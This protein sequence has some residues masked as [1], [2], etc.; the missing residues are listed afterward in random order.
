MQSY[1]SIFHLRFM[2]FGSWLRNLLPNPIARKIFFYISFYKICIFSLHT[3]V[4][5]LLGIYF[6][7]CCKAGIQLFFFHHDSVF[8]TPSAKWSIF[9][10]LVWEEAL[11]YTSPYGYMV[12]CLGSLFYLLGQ[13][14]CS[15]TTAPKF[16]Y[17]SFEICLSQYVSSVA[18]NGRVTVSRLG[19]MHNPTVSLTLSY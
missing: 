9:F 3:S 6:C 16:Y 13:F 11:L 4:F 14:A 7:I 5:N 2:L 17:G 12:W 8:P 10:P 19:I 18:E 15:Y 1:P